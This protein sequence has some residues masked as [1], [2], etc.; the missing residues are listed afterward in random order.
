MKN[1]G[2]ERV[3]AGRRILVTG[4]S[5]FTGSWACLWLREIGATV[6][7]LSLPGAVSSPSLNEA[8]GL[9]GDIEAV[10]CDIREFPVLAAAV[11]RIR[12]EAI[13]H[14]AAQ[15]LV[16]RSY[17]EP[18]ATFSIN[19]MGTA[20]VIEA[21]RMAGVRALVCVTTDK[22]YENKEWP[23]P[24]REVDPLGGKDPYS[25]SKAAAEVIA[26]GY[27]NA[28]PA[29]SRTMPA[30][31]TARGGNI[32]GGGDWAEDR[33]IPDFVRAVDLG[34][35]LLIRHP[36][37]VRPWQ[38]VLA[39]VQGYLMLIA[40]LLEGDPDA[41]TAWNFGPNESDSL[42]VKDVIEII[43]ENWVQPNVIIEP[44]ET[45]AECRLLRLDSSL[46]RERLGWRLPWDTRRAIAETAVWYRGYYAAPSQARELTERQLSIWREGL[47]A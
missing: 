13:L 16:R 17:R 3:L 4:H 5:G 14:L 22:V 12:P 19:A 6:Y 29:A 47:E 45:V 15:P 8:A 36:E 23:W 31:A 33:L 25:A 1:L 38:H 26:A 28:F 18:L 7:G 42:T 30:I 20:N 39:L 21:A 46:A 2:F 41:A 9:A 11:E 10:S 24:Y 27:R 37:A 44:S 35:P 40:K 43:A 32:I 34:K